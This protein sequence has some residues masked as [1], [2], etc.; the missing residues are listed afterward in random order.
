MSI[1]QWNI[2]SLNRQYGPG[3]KPLID[4]FNPQIICLQETKI[5]SDFKIQRYKDYPYKHQ[6]NLIA[7]GGTSIYVRSD[8]ICRPLKLNTQLP[9][10]SDK[11][12]NISTF[13]DMFYILATW[14]SNKI[15]TTS[16]FTEP[17]TNSIHFVR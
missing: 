6:N 3:L 10:Y 13:D 4:N 7:A 2:R 15:G 14:C 17:V 11:N 1:L 12:F 9:S 5:S 16:K 8:V